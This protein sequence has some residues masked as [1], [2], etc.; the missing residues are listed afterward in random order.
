MEGQ[1]E[2]ICSYD[3][4]GYNSLMPFMA[5]SFANRGNDW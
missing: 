1:C 3:N 5:G 4:S 2:K